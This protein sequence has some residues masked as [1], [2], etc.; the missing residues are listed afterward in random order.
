MN[1]DPLGVVRLL[2]DLSLMLEGHNPMCL[3]ERE[4]L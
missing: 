3:G 2:F 1:V 4:V